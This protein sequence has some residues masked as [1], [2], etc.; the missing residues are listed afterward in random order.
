MTMTLPF[1]FIAAFGVFMFVDALR[2]RA[3]RITLTAPDERPMTQRLLDTLFVPA[4]ERVLT[5]G[6]VDLRLHKSDLARRLARASYPPPFAAPE[7]VMSYRL[8]TAILFALF[9][10]IF[11]LVVGLGA[12]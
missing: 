3:P 4:A 7:V 6:R 9:G 11:G 5:L 10:G 2:P 8:F 1:A 12:A